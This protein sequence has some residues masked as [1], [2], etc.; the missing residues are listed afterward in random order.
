VRLS[1]AER[2]IF[3]H[4]DPASLEEVLREKAKSAKR[5]LIATDGV[6]SMDGDVAPLPAIQKLADEYGAITYVDDAHGDGVMGPEGRGTI[7]Y[8]GLQSKVDVDVGTFSKAFGAFG[9]YISGKSEL[10]EFAFNKSRTWLLSAGHPPSVWATVSAAIDVMLMEPQHLKNL[11]DNTRY[12]KKRLAEMGFN[13]GA[14]ETP[15]T[16]VIVGES[17]KAQELSKR[18]FDDGV[19]ALPIVFPMVAKDRAR[20]RTMMNAALTREDLD[21]ALQKFEK[22]GKSMRIIG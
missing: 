4:R 19:F 17:A 22:I 15:I 18:L 20:I 16:P 1:K 5:I 21:L 2:T 3:K 11:W 13:T 14:S 10:K 7:H 6:F 8:F 12:F 9:G